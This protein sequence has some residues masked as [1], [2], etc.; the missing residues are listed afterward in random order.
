MIIPLAGM[1]DSPAW[2]AGKSN[3]KNA[4]LRQS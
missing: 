4:E 3:A 1:T 2:D